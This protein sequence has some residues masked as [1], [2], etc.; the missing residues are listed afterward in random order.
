[1][2]NKYDFLHRKSNLTHKLP[3]RIRELNNVATDRPQMQT[4]NTTKT[5]VSIVAIIDM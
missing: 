3:T 1:M 5:S 2:V 4:E